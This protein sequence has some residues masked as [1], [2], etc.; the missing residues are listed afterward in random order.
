VP[1]SGITGKRG[2]MINSLTR[3]FMKPTHMI[4]S[5]AQQSFGLNY[6][7]PTGAERDAVVVVRKAEEISYGEE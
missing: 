4:G 2:G 5:Y 3:I 6:Y 1:L 7:G